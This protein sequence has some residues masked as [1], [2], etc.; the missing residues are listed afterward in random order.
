[1]NGPLLFGKPCT[2]VRREG[3]AL[4][5]EFSI[6]S[7][8]FGGLSFE[9]QGSGFGGFDRRERSLSYILGRRFA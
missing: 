4:E 5:F 9:G 1:M 6:S 3:G 2:H 8:I 7:L